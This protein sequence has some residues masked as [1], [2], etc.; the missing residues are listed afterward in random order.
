MKRSYKLYL[1]AFSI[2]ILCGIIL[3][4]L[5]VHQKTDMQSQRLYSKTNFDNIAKN[6][7][8]IITGEIVSISEAKWANNITSKDGQKNIICRDVTVNIIEYYKNIPDNP[9]TI[10]LRIIGGT[11]GTNSI[12]S[13]TDEINIRKGKALLILNTPYPDSETGKPVYELLRGNFSYH[14]LQNDN[15]RIFDIEPGISI[16]LDTLKTDIN[17]VVSHN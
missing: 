4:P 15:E 17:R 8:A 3:I 9:K 6:S 11:I 10:T 13:A 1:I 14:S 5:L 7:H 2:S 16:N 12:S